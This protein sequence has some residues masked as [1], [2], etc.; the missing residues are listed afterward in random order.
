MKVLGLALGILLLAIGCAHAVPVTF[1]LTLP[2]WNSQP[3]TCSAAVGDTCKDLSQLYVWMRRQGAPATDST[4]ACTLAVAGMAGKA[5]SFNVDQPEGT[6]DFWCVVADATANR[7]CLSSKVTNTL[8]L[9]PSPV[10]GF[11]KK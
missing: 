8:V 6:F 1:D 2:Q 7:S 11:A 10:T 9:S 5:I 3:G 4:L